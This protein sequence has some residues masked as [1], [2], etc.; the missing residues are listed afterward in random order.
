M[1][2]HVCH[3]HAVDDVD[4][5]G[6]FSV[7][8]ALMTCACHRSRETTCRPRHG[9]GHVASAPEQGDHVVGQE[10]EVLP[11][12]RTAVS[13]LYKTTTFEMEFTAQYLFL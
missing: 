9:A 1:Q 3:T 4:V 12:G 8:T 5:A 2:G 13:K 6:G 7:I 11:L 10:E